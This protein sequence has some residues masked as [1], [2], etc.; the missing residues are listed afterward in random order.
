MLS[1]MARL[2]HWIAQAG[3]LTGLSRLGLE[4]QKRTWMP[5]IRALN[6]H[7][8]PA[9]ESGVFDAQLAC[10]A[11]HF[12]PV[13]LADLLALAAGK[14]PHRRPGLIL[15]FDDGLASHAQV[16]APLLEK[17]GFVG[18]F[19]VPTGFVDTPPALQRAFADAHAIHVRQAAGHDGRVA[20]SWDELRSLAR[21]H[22]IGCHTV[23]HV[24]FRA[25]HSQAAFEHESVVSKRRLEEELAEPVDVFAWVGGEEESY[26]TQGAAAIRRAGFRVALMTNNHVFRAGDDLLQVQRTNIETHYDPALT[27]L[28]LSGLYDLLY[29][30]KRRRVVALTRAT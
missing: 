28:H 23:D 5:F 11:R 3:R 29:G 26:S 13:G 27:A 22:V 30:P 4:F 10:Y 12:E 15:S 1:R 9:S 21:R 6:Y 20:M 19:M 24:R 18:W 2:N 7:D 17:H 25:D 14:W 16:V 8:V